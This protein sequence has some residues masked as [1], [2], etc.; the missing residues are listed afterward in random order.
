MS[1]QLDASSAPTVFPTA[2]LITAM[3]KGR[4]HVS[5][6][7]FSPG[8]APQIEVSG[9]LTELKFRGLEK[10]LPQHTHR[11]ALDLIGMNEH[12]SKE[13]DEKGSADL[14]YSIPQLARF[15]VNIF[16]QRGTIA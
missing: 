8:H 5:D 2:Q 6:L 15:R 1:T 12:P 4:D 14:S 13:L 9:Q 10:L 16:R 11:I 7:V 3:L